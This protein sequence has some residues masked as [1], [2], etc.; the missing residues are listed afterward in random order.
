MK[1]IIFSTNTKLVSGSVSRF[2]LFDVS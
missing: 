1:N 2:N